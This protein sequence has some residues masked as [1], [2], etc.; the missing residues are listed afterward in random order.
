MVLNRQESLRYLY[1]VNLC[2]CFEVLCVIAM[3]QSCPK[4]HKV[5]QRQYIIEIPHR[6]IAL[7]KRFSQNVSTLALE[8][9][10]LL[11]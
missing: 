3:P 5:T 4:N 8:L 2:A 11:F 6:L 7:E 10:L 1:F 9:F